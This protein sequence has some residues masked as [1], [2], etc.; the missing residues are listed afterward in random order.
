MEYTVISSVVDS[1]KTLKGFLISSSEC[2]VHM[3]SLDVLKKKHEQ[4]NEDISYTNAVYDPQFGTL[5]GT[6]ESLT[7]YPKIDY[8]YNV[9]GKNG[10]IVMY[11]IEDIDT[12]DKVGAVV[13]TGTGRRLNLSFEKIN[14]MLRSNTAANFK[15]IVRGT[16]LYT[17]RKDGAEFPVVK[18][19]RHKN[20]NATYN[21]ALGESKP[22]VEQKPKTA[23]DIPDDP[24]KL[25]TVRVFGLKIN[26]SNE[27]VS[28]TAGQNML[29]ASMNI[30][31]LAP[32]YH[33]I[34]SSIERR[35][36]E[37][38]GTMA[39]TET[40]LYYDMRMP[41]TLTIGQLTF[42]LLHE[43]FHIMMQ[44]A[45]RSKGKNHSLWNV[46]TDLYINEII[47]R[48]FDI[49]F[50]DEE[51][52]I[53][54]QV[55]NPNGTTT[56]LKGVIAPPPYG[57]FLDTIGE[58][59]DFARDTPETIYARLLKENPQMPPLGGG[60]GGDDQSGGM[61]MPMD[62]NPSSNSQ[63]GQ[64]QDQNQN[65]SQG[66]QQSS[67]DEQNGQSGGSGQDSGGQQDNDQQNQNGQGQNNKN[68]D[69]FNDSDGIPQDQL[70]DADRKKLAE[71]QA[72]LAEEI[73]KQL[74]EGNLRD[75]EVTYNGK[76]IKGKMM[77]DISTNDNSNTPESNERNIED[78]KRALQRAKTKVKMEEE[79]LGHPLDRNVGIGAG[80]DLIE[81]HID[82]GLNEGV[83]WRLLMKNI[84]VSKPK[85]MYTL[86]MPNQDYMS[87]GY[88]LAERHKIGKPTTAAKFIIAIDVS[89]SVDDKKL[90][91]FMGDVG[92]L[93]AHYKVEAELVYWSTEVGD[94]GF[95]TDLRDLLKVQPHSTGGTDVKCVFDYATRKVQTKTGKTEPLPAR[96]IRAVF[97]IT[98]GYFDHNYG[99]YAQNF[100][101]KTVWLIDG[102]PV[103]FNPMF[104]RVFGL[105][106]KEEEHR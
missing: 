27:D 10:L 73:K 13:L 43:V 102:D 17:I 94:A 20:P 106:S 57:I 48:D 60:G 39:A 55:D 70:S 46:A 66:Q 21:S 104:G 95:F 86:A 32:Y 62:G 44:H 29:T 35:M 76:K 34:Y 64:G 75:V 85:K 15:I 26:A 24:D 53:T 52:E 28:R 81:R 101:K 84:A 89:G 37:R 50:G 36:V 83:D 38:L 8:N 33:C 9:V 69:V 40:T 41:A 93:L 16:S 88:T 72:K 56:T 65:Q 74:Q 63:S 78:S 68:Q 97:I 11:V 5:N 6:F 4:Y 31:K 18:M 3:V 92:N 99:E 80:G 59:L 22:E 7:S 61:S 67:S 54:I 58:T 96:D 42:M 23:L 91:E 90:N 25:P 79:R 105:K 100:G 49:R 47:C 87:M 51:K 98:D 19:E 2:S 82:F 30:Q 77:V 14:S 103:L 71:E 45:G 1:S 12:Q